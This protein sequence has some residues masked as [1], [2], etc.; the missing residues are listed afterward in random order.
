RAVRRLRA[1]R[2]PARVPRA[3]A[4][5]RGECLRCR[6]KGAEAGRHVH[7]AD[8][9]EPHR[10]GA[11]RL[12]GSD[13]RSW[14]RD[15]L[16][17][18][19]EDARQKGAREAQIT[20]DGGHR[21]PQNLCRLLADQPAEV[22]VLDGPRRAWVSFLQ[23][24]YRFIELDHRLDAL[25]REDPLLIERHLHLAARA[26]LRI[27]PARVVDQAA[28]HGLRGA[29]QEVRATLELNASA[30]DE[31]QVRTVHE[32]GRIERV[33]AP[34]PHE[35]LM[36]RLPQLAVQRR[37]KPVERLPVPAAP[38]KEEMRDVEVIV[39]CCLDPSGTVSGRTFEN[40]WSG[41]RRFLWTAHGIVG[42]TPENFNARPLARWV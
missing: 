21:H 19:F 8:A 15:R 22:T 29:R 30:V 17:S 18:F 3:S 5:P 39:H 34:L 32:S 33:V 28:A 35:V 36:G 20:L 26:L 16:T 37:K 9:P 42:A 27:A 2:R 41:S 25:T 23:P 1:R 6:H 14:L 7:R 12:R 24:L 31:L 10:I 11:E 38:L 13:R 4:R 40:A